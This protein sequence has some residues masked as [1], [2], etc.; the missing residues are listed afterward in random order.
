[1]SRHRIDL[2]IH[3]QV[4]YTADY[5]VDGV[6][7]VCNPRGYTGLQTVAGFDPVRTITLLDY[8]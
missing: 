5:R 6:R 4:H 1:M 8:A 2:W 3:G 7:V